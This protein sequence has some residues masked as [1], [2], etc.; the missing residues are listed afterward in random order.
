MRRDPQLIFFFTLIENSN[1][2]A[3]PAKTVAVEDTREFLFV[4]RANDDDMM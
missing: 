3:L 2:F 1:P 4:I